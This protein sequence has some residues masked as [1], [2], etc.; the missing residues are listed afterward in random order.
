M[1]FCCFFMFVVTS[2]LPAVLC[3]GADGVKLSASR[4]KAPLTVKLLAP[5]HLLEKAKACKR[6]WG[7]M[8]Y[9]VD[10]GDGSPNAGRS[11]Q[12]C[13]EN[14][15]HVYSV[16]G[17]YSVTVK[18]FHPGPTDA[19]IYD[20]QGSADV[21]VE[22]G[23]EA[24][25]RV[26]MKILEEKDGGHVYF[27]TGLPL[28]RFELETS[29][30]LEL[31]AELVNAGGKVLFREKKTSSFSGEDS[32]RWG[33]YGNGPA[34]EDYVNGKIKAHYRITAMDS[35]KEVVR[36]ESRTFTIHAETTFRDFEASPLRGNVPLEVTTSNQF[37]HADCASYI[38]EWGDGSSD[39]SSGNYSPR[40]SCPLQPYRRVE[41][42]R[43]HG[44]TSQ[45]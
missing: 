38:V 39:E 44:K 8:G 29:R 31:I 41:G 19:P 11:G 10:W 24:S 37:S 14:L 6:I 2:L 4:G 13:I 45:G 26:K 40:K 15:S 32:I 33:S 25:S 17:K 1:R 9:S 21:E 23:K 3:L 5:A 12:N 42:P 20:F 16:P 36:A 18:V 35:G 28:L 7:G 43:I 27:G 34:A 22:G 30:P